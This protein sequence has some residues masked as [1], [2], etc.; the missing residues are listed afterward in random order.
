MGGNISLDGVKK[1]YGQAVT[2]VQ[3]PETIKMAT[4]VSLVAAVSFIGMAVLA[5]VL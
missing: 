2:L 4:I 1:L 5:V 3:N